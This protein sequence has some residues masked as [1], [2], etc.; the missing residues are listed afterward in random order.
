MR[1]RAPKIYL[2]GGKAR[3]G[4]S[5]VARLIKAEYELRGERAAI[6]SYGRYIKDYARNYFG[7]DGKEETKPRDLLQYLGAEII[8]KKLHKK[9]FF[10][11]RM[12]DDIQI[13]SY[14][15]DVIIIDDARLK[16]EVDKLRKTFDLFIPI[17]VVRDNFDN[18][19][20]EEQKKDITEID[21]DKYKMFKYCIHNDGELDDLKKKVSLI[22]DGEEK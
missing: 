1:K 15:F 10:V 12:I 17:K 22:I 9:D 3:H 2:I 13:L 6:T 21:L 16:V 8:R 4:K 5:T 18:G 19:L 20:T 7:W 14:F 11:N